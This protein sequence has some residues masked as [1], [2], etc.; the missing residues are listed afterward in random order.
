MVVLAVAAFAPPAAYSNEL[1]R[2]GGSPFS[3]QAPVGSDSTS[4][5]DKRQRIPISMPT[6]GSSNTTAKSDQMATGDE[7]VGIAWHGEAATRGQATADG[8]AAVH[9][10]AARS[11]RKKKRKFKNKQDRRTGGL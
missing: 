2:E 6:L 8:E 9:D 7:A 11:D 1:V 4:G 5:A 3:T 10:G